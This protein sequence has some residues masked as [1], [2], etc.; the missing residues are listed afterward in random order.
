MQATWKV[1]QLQGLS[2]PAK[3]EILNVVFAY[4]GPDWFVYVASID[5]YGGQS[6]PCDAGVC[7]VTSDLPQWR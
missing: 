5:R 4:R 6:F 7:D 2:R 1:K 3:K